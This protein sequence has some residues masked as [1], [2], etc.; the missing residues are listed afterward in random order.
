[1]ESMNY[2]QIIIDFIVAF[3]QRP[4][5]Y[6]TKDTFELCYSCIS[7]FESAMSIV[8][9]INYQHSMQRWLCNK[10]Q[11]TALVWGYHIYYVMASEDEKI[12]KELVFS[13]YIQ[14]LKECL[15]S[16]ELLIPV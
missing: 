9:G 5:M 8:S 1:M 16:Q 12:A 15:S 4:T 11:N 7:G 6:V 3:E 13:E 14:F 2:T 10:S